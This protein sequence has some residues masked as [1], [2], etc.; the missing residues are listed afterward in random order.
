LEK[1]Q[2]TVAM[3]IANRTAGDSAALTA[4]GDALAANGWLD[5][6]HVCYLLSPATSLIGGAGTPAARI[7]LLGSATPTTTSTDG[8]DLESVKLTELVEFAFSLAPTVKGQEPFL[9]FPHLQA[10]RLYHATKLAD[11]GHVSQA[12]KY[13]EAIVN[14]LKATT[15]PSPYYTPVLVAQVK[16]LSDRLTAAPGHDK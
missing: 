15:K 10:L 9:G 13:C 8:I 14:T 7:C 1:W 3:I 4:L 12:S 6:A 16:A 11:A 2:E 5:A